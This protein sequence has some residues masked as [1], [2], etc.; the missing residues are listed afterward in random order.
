MKYVDF[1]TPKRAIAKVLTEA[2]NA[3][4]K[5]EYFSLFIYE[6]LFPICSPHVA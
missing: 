2:K 4:I 6:I 1:L 5:I 3:I